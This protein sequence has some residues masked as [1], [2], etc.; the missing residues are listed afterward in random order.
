MRRRRGWRGRVEYTPGTVFIFEM[1]VMNSKKGVSKFC[2]CAK[3]LVAPCP[4]P[5]INCVSRLP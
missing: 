1:Y 5:L 3:T 4:V 2:T